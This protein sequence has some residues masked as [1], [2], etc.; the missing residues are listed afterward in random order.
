[1]RRFL[2]T[3][4]GV[5]LGMLVS[6]AAFAG[7]IVP[8]GMGMYQ[9]GRLIDT[10]P[11]SDSLIRWYSYGSS[12]TPEAADE[13]AYAV[14]SVDIE[15]LAFRL[16]YGGD[17]PA[18]EVLVAFSFKPGPVAPECLDDVAGNCTL[19]KT[20]CM[21]S[22]RDGDF[23]L[24]SVYRVFIYPENLKVKA[25]ELGITWESRLYSLVR[26]EL[27]HVLGL[28]HDGTGPMANGESPFTACQLAKWREFQLDGSG[29]WL[30]PTLNECVPLRL[31]Q[32]VSD[33]PSKE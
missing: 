4:T 25:A 12:Q 32:Q 30:E 19:G 22:V 2:L 31:A 17:A 33:C 7:G 11:A 21:T 14:A 6:Q 27:G 24:C 26:H 16:L 20:E 9:D 3:L 13:L 18:P 10:V 8:N 29:A 15:T 28:K 1:V 5:L 23:R